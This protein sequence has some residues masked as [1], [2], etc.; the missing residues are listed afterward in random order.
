MSVENP[1]VSV[2][3][4]YDHQLFC[5]ANTETENFE[6][7]IQWKILQKHF[8]GGRAPTFEQ[9][10]SYEIKNLNSQQLWKDSFTDFFSDHTDITQTNDKFNLQGHFFMYKRV[11]TISRTT[12]INFIKNEAEFKLNQLKLSAVETF[13]NINPIEPEETILD[14]V[15]ENSKCEYS[16]IM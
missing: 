12:N 6:V 7:L 1:V 11:G 3:K 2:D 16:E 9:S 5:L 4:S 10:F 14:V 13:S 15:F 8:P